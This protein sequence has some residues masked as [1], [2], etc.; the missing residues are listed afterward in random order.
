[1][2]CITLSRHLPDL[3]L[4]SP[5]SLP[6]TM[7]GHTTTPNS[8]FQ[9][10]VDALADYANQTGIN[11]TQNPF[12]EKLQHSNTPDAILELLQEREKSFKEY[13]DGNRRLISCLS[14]AVRVLHAFSST[15]GEAISLVSVVSLTRISA[16]IL[17]FHISRYPSHRQR[18]SLS[19]LMFSS[20][21]VPPT[22][23]SLR[24]PCNA[25]D[26]RLLVGSV[27]VTMLSSNSSSAW[28]ASSSASTFIL[29]FR[30]RH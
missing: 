7:S 12:V 3:F 20:L 18:R 25:W 2:V 22:Q 28:A 4:P 16:L 27:Q 29:T 8:N 24:S 10:I 5:R 19:A 14:P 21:Y 15:L 6:N 9:L 30:Q 26:H 17:R 11:L 1:M 13:R 23:I